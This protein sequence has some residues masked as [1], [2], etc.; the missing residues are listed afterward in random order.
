[1]ALP[2]IKVISYTCN[3]MR[4]SA[5]DRH[6]IAIKVR[7]THLGL[8]HVFPTFP[9]HCKLKSLQTGEYQDL[10]EN[11]LHGKTLRFKRFSVQ[12][13]VPTLNSEFK[14]SGDMTWQEVFILICPLCFINGKINP[15][16]K[17]SRFITNLGQFPL[18]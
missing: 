8:D 3:S 15:I 18:V 14:I 2:T 6:Q 16:L 17:C 12:S 4:L 11:C 9:F 7:R 1:M 10:R 5:S 13:N